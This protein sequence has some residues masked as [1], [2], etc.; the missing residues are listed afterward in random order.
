MYLC[1][2]QSADPVLWR[3]RRVGVEEITQ[4]GYVPE[5]QSLW[6]LTSCQL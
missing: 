2:G 6:A 1:W 3:A 5:A 4:Q